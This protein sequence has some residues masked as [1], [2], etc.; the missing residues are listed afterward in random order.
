MS[1]PAESVA[2][3]LPTAMHTRALGEAIGRA[4]RRGDWIAL[5]GPLGAG[6][7]ALVQGIAA[8]LGVSDDEP[9]ISPTFVLVREYAGRERLFHADLFRLGG[10]DEL[11]MIG[12]AEMRAMGVVAVEWADRFPSQVPAEALRVAME[13]VGEAR[14]AALTGVEQTVLRV[15]ADFREAE[16]R[17]SSGGLSG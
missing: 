10:A 9:V 12:L 8:G 16:R 14:R 15:M 6:K 3:E 2:V 11:E 5:S 1:A 13:Y 4:A 17:V 7:T